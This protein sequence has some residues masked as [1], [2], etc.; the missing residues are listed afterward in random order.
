MK[1][2]A[3]VAKG[4]LREELAKSVFYSGEDMDSF[5]VTIFT[6]QEEAAEYIS[7]NPVKYR[8]DLEIRTIDVV[9]SK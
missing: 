6:S 5:T 3:I 9:V 1:V 8:K 4:A 7:M 2:Y